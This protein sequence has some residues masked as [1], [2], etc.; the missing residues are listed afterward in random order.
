MG[1]CDDRD[2]VLYA[3][4][5]NTAGSIYSELNDLKNAR[6]CWESA[7]DIRKRQ[8]TA[9]EYNNTLINMANLYSAEGRLNEALAYF[10]DAEIGRL[11]LDI[12][13]IIGLA[14][15]SLGIGRAQ[16]LKGDYLSAEI[17]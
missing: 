15:C 17:K 2:S 14:L 10:A 8:D 1:T 11:K 9:E 6:P 4:L 16:S 13:S 12:D 5:A 3:H 7:L